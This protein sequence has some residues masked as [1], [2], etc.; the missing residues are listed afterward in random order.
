MNRD[1]NHVAGRLKSRWRRAE[2]GEA[3]EGAEGRV[4]QVRFI[5]EVGNGD[6]ASPHPYLHLF[7]LLFC[8]RCAVCVLGSCSAHVRLDLSSL[9][10]G[11]TTGC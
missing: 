8:Q 5:S 9:A 6:A 7:P 11:L 4:R 3:G 1:E 2:V 10:L